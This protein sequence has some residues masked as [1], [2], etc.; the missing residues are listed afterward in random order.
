MELYRG[1]LIKSVM[2]E[3]WMCESRYKKTHRAVDPETGRESWACSTC[4]EL[5]KII[6]NTVDD[7]E[8]VKAKIDTIG[9]ELADKIAEMESLDS[10]RS[11]L[12]MTIANL[13]KELSFIKKSV[14]NFG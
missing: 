9:S 6:D 11:Q 14:L 12:E 3:D 5:K 4:E 1:Y 13:R 7:T 2:E 8:H 10:E